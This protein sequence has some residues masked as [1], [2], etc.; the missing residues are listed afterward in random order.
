MAPA[1]A[2]AAGMAVRGAVPSDSLS[3]LSLGA[4]AGRQAGASGGQVVHVH[5]D[6]AILGKGAAAEIMELIGNDVRGMINAG[7]SRGRMGESR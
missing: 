5:L 2:G 7:Y 6:G 4:R 1:L 3:G